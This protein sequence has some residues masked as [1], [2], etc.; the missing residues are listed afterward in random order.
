MANEVD[1]M[2]AKQRNNRDKKMARLHAAVEK[3]KGGYSKTC[4]RCGSV[5]NDPR[6]YV[7]HTKE[8]HSSDS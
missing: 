2:T 6:T 7:E 1:W 3:K 8:P 4:P 5:F